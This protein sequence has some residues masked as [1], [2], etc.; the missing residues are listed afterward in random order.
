MSNP[1]ISRTE[2]HRYSEACAEAGEAFAPVALRLA[3]S[4]RRLLR[5]IEQ[6]SEAL[7]VEEAQVAGHMTTVCL[8]VLDQVG[9]RLARVSGSDLD[10]AAVR[11]SGLVSEVLPLDEK[12]P[13]RVRRIESRA[14]PNLLDEVLWAL[15]EVRAK[16]PEEATFA[17]DRS[18]LVFLTMWTVIEAL[19]ACW[20]APHDYQPETDPPGGFQV[21]EPAVEAAPEG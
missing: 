16:K 9:G 10:A 2:V 8:R 18:G 1:T 4:Q 13:E 19:D 5:F 17:V 6:N 21:P 12:L 14:Q 7:G 3:R 20:T 11:V 15:F